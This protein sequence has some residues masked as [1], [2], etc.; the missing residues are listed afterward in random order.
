MYSQTNVAAGKQFM[1]MPYD[2]RTWNNKNTIISR[3]CYF[4]V[5][6]RYN[7][8]QSLIYL[9]DIGYLILYSIFAKAWESRYL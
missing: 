2:Y 9:T 6:S 5:K 4:T 8:T 7:L 1:F 3:I